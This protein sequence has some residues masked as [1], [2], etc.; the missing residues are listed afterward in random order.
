MN[1]G[2][3]KHDRILEIYSRLLSGELI[4]KA[5]LAEEYGVNPRSIQRDIDSIRDFY[6]NR[7]TQTGEAAEIRYDHAQKGFRLVSSKTVALTNAE[8]FAISKILME[9]RSL[10]KEEM[11]HIVE[12]LIEACLPANERKKMAD[13]IRNELFHY[14]EPRHQ[15]MLINRIWELGTAVYQHH[16]VHLDYQKTNGEVTH[17]DIK[18]VG[19][20][21]SEYYFYLIAYIGEHDKNILVIRPYTVLTG[22]QHIKFPKKP[23]MY[24]TKIGLKKVNFGNG[25][26]SCLVESCIK[27]VLPIPDLIL[28][29]Y[30]IVCLQPPP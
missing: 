3:R 11:E 18:P 9:S 19:I 10:C 2:T 25:F 29:P 8:L 5:E 15:K 17:A 28:T 6:A 13:L 16:F 4:R 22:L 21:C 30:W 12:E 27:P 23:S 26:P 24:P 7:A 20:I 1:D 14:V